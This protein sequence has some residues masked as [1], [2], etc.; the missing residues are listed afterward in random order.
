MTRWGQS[1]LVCEEIF[2]NED[3][4]VPDRLPRKAVDAASLKCS[5]LGW[6]GL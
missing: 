1:A 2:H 6:T 4:E 3:A 5:K